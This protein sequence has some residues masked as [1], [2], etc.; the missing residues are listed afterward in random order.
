M[1]KRRVSQA[2]L[3]EVFHVARIL[4][5][6]PTPKEIAARGDC[7]VRQVQYHLHKAIMREKRLRN[8]A[9]R[10]QATSQSL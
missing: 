4:A 9:L 10:E 6:L 7:H 1:V 3:D 8:L 5:G 2:V